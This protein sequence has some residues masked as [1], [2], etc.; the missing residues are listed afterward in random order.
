MPKSLDLL[1]M[2]FYLNPNYT[3]ARVYAFLACLLH[4]LRE[5][6]DDELRSILDATE[7]YLKGA[8]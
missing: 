8:A 7:P 3:S 5:V 4:D 2:D 6:S 1:A